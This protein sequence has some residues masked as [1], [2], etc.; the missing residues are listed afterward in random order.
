MTYE[1]AFKIQQEYLPK[2]VGK[3][4]SK[5]MEDVIEKIEI[6]PKGETNEDFDLWVIST[7]SGTP[8]IPKEKPLGSWL[9]DNP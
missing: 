9:Q 6:R 5:D 3:R 4:I 2:V 7:I 1:Q 8:S